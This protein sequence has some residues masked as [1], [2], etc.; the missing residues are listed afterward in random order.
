MFVYKLFMCNWPHACIVLLKVVLV[1]QQQ[2]LFVDPL[3]EQRRVINQIKK[4]WKYV[5]H[6]IYNEIKLIN[7]VI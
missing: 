4:N 5:I 3:G 1:K 6:F 7:C 2:L